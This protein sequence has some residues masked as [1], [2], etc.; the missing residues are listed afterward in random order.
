M[1][2]V[3]P[4]GV[5]VLDGRLPVTFVLADA[6]VAIDARDPGRARAVPGGWRGCHAPPAEA[7]QAL[8]ARLLELARDIEAPAP[9][10]GSGLEHALDAI[11]ASLTGARRSR[12]RD[13]AKRGS[14]ARTARAKPG[15]G[16]AEISRH[17]DRE[18]PGHA[19]GQERRDFR[20]RHA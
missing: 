2:A 1:F 18:R 4:V 3:A 20:Y 14:G 9:S 10:G 12:P 5:M 15:T 6:R 13:P 8:C 17:R 7:P 16:D 11:D 19:A